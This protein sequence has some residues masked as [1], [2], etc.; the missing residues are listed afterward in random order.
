MNL[1]DLAQDPANVARAAKLI[2]VND[3]MPGLSRRTN[4]DHYDYLDPKGQPVEDEATLA[5]IRQMAL[6]PAYEHVWI[7]PKTQRPFA[8]N[9]H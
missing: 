7:C 1:L 3:T 5:R 4:G 9:G 2:Y 8:G 6:P